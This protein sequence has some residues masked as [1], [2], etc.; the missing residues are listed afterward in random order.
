VF[1]PEQLRLRHKHI[2]SRVPFLNSVASFYIPVA[3][4]WQV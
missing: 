1:Y 4:R 2:A 3:T